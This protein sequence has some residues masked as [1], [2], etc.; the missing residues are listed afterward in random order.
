MLYPWDINEDQIP[1]DLSV[2]VWYFYA[3]I[4]FSAHDVSDAERAAEMCLY[5]L[6][7]LGERKAKGFQYVYRIDT[8][9][10]TC[11]VDAN[12]QQDQVQRIWTYDTEFQIVGITKELAQLRFQSV[13]EW[14]NGLATLQYRNFKSVGFSASRRAA[15]QIRHEDLTLDGMVQVVNFP[16]AAMWSLDNEDYLVPVDSTDELLN[17]DSWESLSLHTTSIHDAVQSLSLARELLPRAANHIDAWKWIVISL[18]NAV[19]G[20]MVLALKNSNSISVL[21]PS[22]SCGETDTTHV[23]DQLVDFLELYKRVK[24]ETWVNQFTTGN[25]FR[26]SGTQGGSVKTLNRLRNEFVHFTPKSWRLDQSLILEMPRIVDDCVRMLAFLAF[27]SKNV[28]WYREVDQRI[29]TQYAI[30][31]LTETSYQISK[32]YSERAVPII[33][34]QKARRYQL[35][36]P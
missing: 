30:A 13:L 36:K 11:R 31:S 4:A 21:R 35:P 25:V 18:H 7:T 3:S 23:S 19:Q 24:S 34:K 1:S 16:F 8:Y 32:E 2:K 22:N 26:P 33:G 28:Q 29:E 20:F 15:A 12:P 5:Q 6:D 10:N 27:E 14:L 17:Q 9:F